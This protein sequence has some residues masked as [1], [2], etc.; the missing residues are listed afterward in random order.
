MLGFH[1]KANYNERRTKIQTKEREKKNS[2]FKGAN[3]PV[4]VAIR[5]EN[6]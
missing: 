1:W 3:V 4:C 5:L 6:M 2:K